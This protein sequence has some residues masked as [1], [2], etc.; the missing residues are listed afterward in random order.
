MAT[1]R[2]K[3]GEVETRHNEIATE[4]RKIRGVVPYAVESR[5]M[6]GWKEIIEPG[7]LR[8]ANLDELIARVDHAGVPIGRFPKSLDVEDR[9]DGLHWS[10]VPPESRADLR[11]AVERGDLR[12]GSWQMVVGRDRWEDEVRHVEQ[13]AELRDVSVVSAPAYPAAAV[14]YRSAPTN[15][16]EEPKVE[17]EEKVEERATDSSEKQEETEARVVSEPEPILQVEDRDFG[18]G[19]SLFAE[20][21]S[22]GF[23]DQAA[24]MSWDQF[25]NIENRAVTYSGTIDSLGRQPVSGG[26]YGYDQR[27]LW[28]QLPNVAVT[29]GVTSVEV[30]QQT[31]RTLVAGTAALRPIAGTANKAEVASTLNVTTVGLQ[32]VAGVESGVPNVYLERTELASVVEQDLNYQVYDG[33]DSL[34]VTAVASSGFQAPDTGSANL[35]SI[36]KAVTTLTASGYNPNL[37]AL[38]PANAESIDLLVSGLTGGTADFVFGAGQ[39]AP[40]QLFGMPTVVSKGIAASVVADTSAHGKLYVSPINLA[41]FEENAGKTNTS[42]VRL[43]CHA[44]YGTERTAAA[45]RI[46]AS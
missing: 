14:E 38:T 44:A 30:F 13:I 39:F 40:G 5:D 12:A 17:A 41:R 16:E 3:T 35:T 37:I 34:F 10:V 31:S 24:S 28:N 18:S 43:E 7:A 19:Q 15:T 25:R 20:F 26:P 9:S 45:V 2:P 4:G 36:R 23:P 11:E 1:E 42:L 27:Y 8:Q 46:A 33:L 6:G 32:G 21:R 22:A 29:A